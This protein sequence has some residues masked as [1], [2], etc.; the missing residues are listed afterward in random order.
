MDSSHIILY[1]A[2]AVLLVIAF[3]I[4]VIIW[5]HF[6][7]VAEPNEALIISGTKNTKNEA[8]FHIVTGR[9]TLVR[10]LIQQVRRLSLKLREAQLV[11]QCFTVQGVPTGVE[12]VCIY[13]IG[14]SDA[15][16]SNA[17]R[18][19]LGQDDATMDRNI[20]TL[21][22]GHTRG[23]IGS[24]TFEE[25]IRDTEVIA[26]KVRT[27]VTPEVGKLGLMIDSLQINK[28][29]DPTKYIE[30][31]S[32]PHVAA[33]EQQARVARANEDQTA[34]LAEQLAIAA[35]AQAKRNAEVKQSELQAEIDAQQQRAAQA[36]PLAAAQAHQEVLK[37]ETE[38]QRLDAIK[39]E[40]EL[41]VTVKK[42]AEAEAYA[43]ATKADGAKKAAIA[44]AEAAAT[45]VKLA[46][47]AQAYA[48]AQRGDG[49][50]KAAIALA[51]S[52]AAAIELE[53]TAQAN[54]T[55]LNGAADAKA[56]EAV[57]LAEAA[58]TK[59]NL[60]AEADGLRAKGEAMKV[61][62]E[63]IIQQAIAQQLPA[64]VRE[65]AAPLANIKDLVVLNGADGLTSNI[66]GIVSQVMKLWP[67][68]KGG[69][70]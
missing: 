17:A 52:K 26:E 47:E 57:G 61:N 37:Q 58:A 4:V 3:G 25:L 45:Q 30:K 44:Q 68:I 1:A 9:G 67:V 6:W 65:A 64:M 38:I 49:D 36:G 55:Q 13:K 7:Y 23:I 50:K 41:F 51:E 28:L 66:T 22:D 39:K 43:V 20:T 14:D 46:S 11:V 34:T 42:P 31:M 19:F 59:A 8:G 63:V 29:L 70:T 10:P 16:I 62:S 21:L 48:V 24:L 12:G 15:E 27:S 5:K 40:Q 33:V 2:M 56:K 18:R 69:L 60:I 54:A 53:A 32:I 35:N